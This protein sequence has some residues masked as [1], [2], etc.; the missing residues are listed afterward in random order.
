MKFTDKMIAALEAPVGSKKKVHRVS[1]GLYMAVYAPTKDGRIRRSWIARYTLNGV[2][3]PLVLGEF[4][5][6]TVAAAK[7]RTLQIRADAARGISP[8]PATKDEATDEA[9]RGPTLSKLAEEFMIHKS[10]GTKPLRNRTLK[11]YRG[12]L[13]HKGAIQLLISRPASS[14]TRTEMADLHDAI[15][16]RAP[17]GYQA[18]RT[19]QLLSEI[20]DHALNRGKVEV[21]PA[22]KIP[23]NE[24]KARLRFFSKDEIVS[25]WNAAGDLDLHGEALVKLLIL[26]GC[27]V[28]EILGLS[29]DEIQT[30]EEVEG[31]VLLIEGTEGPVSR[32]KNGRTHIVSITPQMSDL[33]ERLKAAAPASKFLFP[34]PDDDRQPV[35]KYEAIV[36]NLR[37]LSKLD[38]PK[39]D[40]KNIRL[41]DC[42]TT[43]MTW[44]QKLKIVPDERLADRCLSHV[45]GGV[46]NKHYNGYDQLPERRDALLKWDKWLL[47]ITKPPESDAKTPDE[48]PA[49]QRPMPDNVVS[50]AGFRAANG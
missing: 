41:H 40:P 13:D 15:T 20:Y 5:D 29:R 4:P 27:R 35:V 30:I 37:K 23:T 17:G 21:N 8:K 48:S 22:R 47:E 6:M 3:E 34:H 11:N 43:L 1:Q 9:A 16:V 18:N 46:G 44:L 49:E 33:I 19:L 25:I 50:L 32:T 39:N 10:S 31:Q 2:R 28:S 14:I 38:A 24:E 12:I 42:R 36:N 26:S 7:R 45:Q